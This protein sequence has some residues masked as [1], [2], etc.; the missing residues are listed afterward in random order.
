MAGGTKVDLSELVGAASPA[1]AR[2]PNIGRTVSGLL[3]GIVI[4]D[5]LAAVDVPRELAF[6][7]L[8]LFLAANV[9]QRVVPAT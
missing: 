6:V 3:A 5:W 8:G 4:V 7:F 2:T 1:G 9:F